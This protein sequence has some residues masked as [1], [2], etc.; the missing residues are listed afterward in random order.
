MVKEIYFVGTDI[1]TLGTKSV[2]VDLQGRILANDYAEYEVLTPQPL[3]AEQWPD[4]WFEAVC[5]TIKNALVKAN[6][7]AG[8]VAGACISGLYGG[9]GI[10]CDREGKPLRPCLIWMDRRATKEVAWVMDA[11]GTDKV[12]EITGNY[13][14]S[15]HGFNKILW[16]KNNE[17]EIWKQIDQL[18]TPYGY[19]IFRL[20]GNKSLDFCSA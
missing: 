5:K 19:C 11:I 12:F 4:V 7:P 9:S 13:V 18:M 1:G 3:W 16:I 10:P 20:T 2:V 15:Y 17:P 14:D 6:V 8:N